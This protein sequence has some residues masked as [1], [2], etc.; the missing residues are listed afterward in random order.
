M[1][2]FFF[3][4]LLLKAFADS[5]SLRFVACDSY[6]RVVLLNIHFK[7]LRFFFKNKRRSIFSTAKLV[8]FSLIKD[9]DLENKCSRVVFDARIAQVVGA[10]IAIVR[11]S[12]RCRDQKSKM[13]SFESS[14]NANFDDIHELNSSTDVVEDLNYRN[15]MIT[16]FLFVFFSENLSC[17][18]ICDSRV[19]SF[20]VLKSDWDKSTN[21]DDVN[22]DAVEDDGDVVDNK[23]DVDT[24]NDGDWIFCKRWISAWS[25]LLFAFCLRERNLLKCFSWGCVIVARRWTSCGTH[26]VT[27]WC[28]KWKL[29]LLA[30]ID[31]FLKEKRYHLNN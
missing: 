21:D 6:S 13:L 7:V 11:N 18:G 8:L 30:V 1:L 29:K 17:K 16:D 28:S 3:D 24:D 26:A 5:F 20:G 10:I 25:N 4:S 27:I 9:F 19:A 14:S 23:V 12:F 22:D 15:I 2:V 31:I